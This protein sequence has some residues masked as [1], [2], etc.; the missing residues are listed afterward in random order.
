MSRGVFFHKGG[1]RMLLLIIDTR[2]EF[3][4]FPFV[5]LAHGA[6]VA[7]DAGP[8]FT[9]CALFLRWC[10]WR[11]VVQRRAHRKEKV[12]KEEMKL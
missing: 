2:I 3:G 9:L 11:F 4:F 10:F 12:R 8:Y 1:G 7:H 5:K 6:M